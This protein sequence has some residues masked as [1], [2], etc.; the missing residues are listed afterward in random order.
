[1]FGACGIFIVYIA[2]TS[3]IAQPYN[4]HNFFERAN[5]REQNGGKVVFVATTEWLTWEEKD[6]I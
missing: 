4:I 6:E 3:P 5:V 1:M 2:N